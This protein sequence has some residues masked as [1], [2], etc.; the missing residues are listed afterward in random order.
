MVARSL[1]LLVGVVLLLVDDDE[2]QVPDRSEH[3]RA[4]SHRDARFAAADAVPL[5]GA[6]V[7]GERR[8]QDGDLFAKDSVQIGGN[9]RRQ[10]DLRHQQNRAAPRAAST[11]C[12]AA[13]YTAVLPE[14]VTP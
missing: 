7:I 14:P 13:R 2:R 8:V 11:C 4:R 10:A 1:L 5:L 9:A 12:I 6:L 3:R